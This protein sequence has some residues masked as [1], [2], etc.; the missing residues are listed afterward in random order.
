MDMGCHAFGWFR[1]MLGGNPKVQSVFAFMGTVAHSA[2]TRGEDNS[3]TIVEFEDSVTGVAENRWA[4]PGG[5]DDRIEVYGTGGVSYADLFA[6]NA[7]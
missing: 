5:M 1:W 4:K 7:A 2:R 6:G 3:I